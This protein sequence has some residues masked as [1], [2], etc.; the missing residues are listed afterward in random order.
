M[1]SPAFFIKNNNGKLNILET[2]K[3]KAYSQLD[4]YSKSPSKISYT[5][6]YDQ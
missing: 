2:N 3:N 6:E 4:I 1:K 5:T